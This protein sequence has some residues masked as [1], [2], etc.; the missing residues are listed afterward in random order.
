[1]PSTGPAPFAPA[2]SASLTAVQV[3]VDRAIYAVARHWLLVVNSIILA[4]LAVAAVAPLLRANGV[5]PWARVIYAVNRPFCHQRDDRSFYLFG[6][7]MACCQRCAAIYGGLFLFGLVFVAL[8]GVGP[9]SWRGVAVCSLPLL[10]DAMT[11]AIGLRESTWG[12]RVATGVLFAGGVAWLVLPNLEAGFTD[13]R[14]QRE[15][16]FAR[17]AEHGRARP[18]RGAPPATAP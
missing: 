2:R 3:A 4:W 10:L 17:L 1:M 14:A 5:E 8:R 18:L 7:K 13:I 6:E 12:L 15:R 9:L 11:Q 16:R